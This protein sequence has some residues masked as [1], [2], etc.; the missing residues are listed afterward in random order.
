MKTKLLVTGILLVTVLALMT[1]PVSAGGTS[2]GGAAVTGNPSS[3]ASLTLNESSI[4]LAPMTPG[5]S[6]TNAS[7]GITVTANEG[8]W[9]IAVSDN[10]GRAV[11][12]G[13]MGNYTAGSYV[14]SPLN[15]DLASPIQLAGTTNSTTTGQSASTP[16]S[17]GSQI[18]SGSGAVNN[19][20]LAPNTFTQPVAYTDP[21]LPAANT[22]RIDLTFT[23][24]YP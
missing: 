14:A 23:L 22:Y 3:Y 15:T 19:Q 20:L 4:L 2:T 17:G 16:I 21:I 6:A 8:G 18:Y 13:Y 5:L 1:A 11:G 7:L 12:K 10:T 9:T 24:T